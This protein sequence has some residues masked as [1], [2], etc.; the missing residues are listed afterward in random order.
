[1]TTRLAEGDS[2]T[3]EEGAKLVGTVFLD[4]TLF[5]I[6]G[7]VGFLVTVFSFVVLIFNFEGTLLTVVLLTPRIFLLCY[8]GFYYYVCYYFTRLIAVALG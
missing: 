8:F 4:V 7:I 6:F 3:F 1:M 2:E 5:G